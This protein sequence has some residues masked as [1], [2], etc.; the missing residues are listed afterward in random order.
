MPLSRTIKQD[1]H[2]LRRLV[3]RQTSL[4]EIIMAGQKELADKIA[5][6]EQAI[7][8]DEAQ[9][10]ANEAAL[11]A[12]I[13]DLKAQLDAAQPIDTQPIIDQL[14]AIKGRLHAPQVP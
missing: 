13:V 5:E 6:L 1:F 12:V 2:Q 8:D 10:D 3:K 9:D 14:E 7:T 4:L 11:N